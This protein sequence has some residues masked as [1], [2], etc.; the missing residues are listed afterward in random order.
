VITEWFGLVAADVVARLAA[1]GLPALADGAVLLGPENSPQ[2]ITSAAPRITFV[3]LGGSITKRVPATPAPPISSPL[4]QALI[5]QP[6]IWTDEQA[7][8][9]DVMSVQYTS[10]VAAPDLKA[11]WDYTAATLYT[12]IQSLHELQEKSWQPTRYEWADSKPGNTKLGSFGRLVSM[13]FTVYVPIL[14]Y[15]LSTPAAV[16]M[17]GLGILP[18]SAEGTIGMNLSGGSSADTITITV[19]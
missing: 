14:R 1:Q 6:W 18:Q 10:G 9:V 15:N 16:A 19:P 7:W 3:P 2:V 17:G 4:Y 13:F 11:N 12:V 5:T 8:R